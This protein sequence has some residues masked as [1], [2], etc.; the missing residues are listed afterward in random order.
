VIG[1]RAS[2]AVLVFVIAV[3]ASLGVGARPASAGEGYLLG[4]DVSSWQ[5]KPR[6]LDVKNAGVRFVIAR[7]TFNN[8]GRDS[9]YVRNRTL[10]RKRGIPFT[11][12]HHAQ[13]NAAAGD[14]IAEANHFVDV[15]GLN[16]NN[17]LPALDLKTHGDLDPQALEEWVRTWLMRVEER[18]G[19]KPMIY[20][21][22]ALWVDWMTDTT[23]FADNGYRFWA[24][25]WLNDT[26]TLPAN[27]WGGHGW[28]LWQYGKAPIPGIR[29]KVDVNHFN[30]TVLAPLRIK[31]N[32]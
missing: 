27:E 15:A 29:G 1:R 32:L 9:E 11:A 17:L 28:T 6:W 31:N 3:A 7:A 14:A 16:G 4:V 21:P 19:V 18:L 30:G 8:T 22:T 26:P 10:L 2:A 24:R 25:D 12:Y 13:P 23:W 5:A 20:A